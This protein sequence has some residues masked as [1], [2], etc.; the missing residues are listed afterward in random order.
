MPRRAL[1]DLIGMTKREMYE[2]KVD[3]TWAID[4]DVVVVHREGLLETPQKGSG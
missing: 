1:D 3:L 2:W 4:G